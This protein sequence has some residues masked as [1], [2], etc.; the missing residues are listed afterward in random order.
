MGKWHAKI[1]GAYITQPSGS[2]DHSENS[3]DLQKQEP[4]K[5]ILYL[6][7]L[8][9]NLVEG[10]PAPQDNQ[11]ESTTSSLTPSV[12]HVYNVAHVL[13]RVSVT[14]RAD[15]KKDSK[16]HKVKCVKSKSHWVR[17]L[18]LLLLLS[19]AGW[20]FVGHQHSFLTQNLRQVEVQPLVVSR[21]RTILQIVYQEC[22]YTIWEDLYPMAW[23]RIVSLGMHL[24][25]SSWAVL[26]KNIKE[27]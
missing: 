10:R 14:P 13:T 16:Q 12:D 21:A 15:N 20:Q 9:S 3:Q 22:Y 23:D 18:F 26:A 6:V 24:Q 8:L 1:P 4:N 17:R 19:A 5:D 27:V 7:H 11:G 2:P 25:K